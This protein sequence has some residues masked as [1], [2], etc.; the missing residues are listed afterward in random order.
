MPGLLRPFASLQGFGQV[1]PQGVPRIDWSHP[2]ARALVFYGFDT[3]TGLI[4]DLARGRIGSW[5]TGG[6]LSIGVPNASPFGTGVKYAGG[7]SAGSIYLF[8]S[9]A[10]IQATNA[11]FPW[12]AACGYNQTGNNLSFCSPFGRIANSNSGQPFANWYFTTNDNNAGQNLAGVT[13]NN[14]G[15]FGRTADWTTNALNRFTSVAF[16]ANTA[17]S[18]G[19]YAQGILQSTTTG[20]TLASF[21]TNDQICFGGSS[22]FNTNGCGVGFTYYGALWARALSAD[23]LVQLHNDPYCFLFPPES[24]MP[25]LPNPQQPVQLGT[26][27]GGASAT[28]VITTGV[29]CPA[30][31]LIVIGVARSSA[32]ETISSIVDTAGNTYTNAQDISGT[33]V[34]LGVRYCPGCLHLSAGSTIT[35]TLSDALAIGAISAFYIPGMVQNTTALD[36]APS[37][38]TG[39]AATSASAV[40]T[41]TLA[42][43]AEVIVGTLATAG[44][45]SAFAPGTGFTSIGGLSQT[46]VS[47]NLAY[48]V[49]ASTSTVSFAP[50]WTT[51]AN[52]A[53]DVVSFKIFIPVAGA[54]FTPQANPNPRGYVPSIALKTS[55]DPIKVNLLGKDQFFGAPGQGP[56]YD[57]PNPVTGR[58]RNWKRDVSGVAVRSQG[59]VLGSLLLGTLKNKDTFFGLGGA[60]NFYWP[61]PTLKRP[62]LEL[63]SFLNPAEIQLIGNDKFF[64]LAG[65]PNFYWPNPTVKKPNLELRTFLNPAEIQLVGKDQFFGLA[66]NPQFDWPNPR[67]ARRAAFEAGAPSSLV[68]PLAFPFSFYAWDNPRSIQRAFFD[69]GQSS[70]LAAFLAP[71]PFSFY[72]WDNPRFARRAAM[73]YAEAGGTGFSLPNS[74]IAPFSV[75]DWP[76]PRGSFSAL[77]RAAL[78][79]TT[80]LGGNPNIIPI[81]PTP[82][83]QSA[84]S[85]FSHITEWDEDEPVNSQ[86]LV[87]AREF[88][89][90]TQVKEV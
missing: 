27:G 51:A 50:S 69:T 4:L 42:Q 48:Q 19:L 77:A 40:A 18:A 65:N 64:G 82:G 59:Q 81:P 44:A 17:S 71:G 68:G 89:S 41:G 63:R 53:N 52:Y 90:I 70:A 38:T 73:L 6:S 7:A 61:N 22:N 84:I 32:T 15:T 16:V 67:A 21:N 45:T 1:K 12:T 13:F 2:L 34:R 29:D 28:Y 8:A 3:G 47:I 56:N 79:S 74:S 35:V 46:G 76:N 86:E 75:L 54:P 26:A 72:A 58:G 87:A 5:A 85:F 10:E 20:I 37:G 66:G 36:A 14:S 33:A 78:M 88:K 43:S 24:E 60:P 9:D 62:N 49:V 39:I 55:F 30:G 57:W 23:E 80:G 83:G 31:S 11:A 25:A